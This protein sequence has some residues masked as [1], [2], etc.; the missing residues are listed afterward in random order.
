MIPACAAVITLVMKRLTRL[1][2]NLFVN[3]I[4]MA[5]N[6]GLRPRRTPPSSLA[7]SDGR[8]AEAA[9]K[10][11]IFFSTA[12][13]D[14]PPTGGLRVP[15]QSWRLE[16]LQELRDGTQQQA[17]IPSSDLGVGFVLP[18]PLLPLCK[19][20]GMRCVPPRPAA[21]SIKPCST[22]AGLHPSRIR[23]RSNAG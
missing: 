6:F 20:Y 8:N 2:L 16:E 21:I 7:A 3:S 9:G 19:G 11:H 10:C 12:S 22:A 4:G 15:E 17:E 13:A 1:L 14:P 18:K 5:G 23:L